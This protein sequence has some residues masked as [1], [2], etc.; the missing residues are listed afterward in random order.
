MIHRFLPFN[1]YLSLLFFGI[2]ML[3]ASG[4]AAGGNGPGIVITP[5]LQY[6]YAQ[7]LFQEQDHIAAQVEFKRFIHFFPDDPRADESE[8]KIGI[9][10]YRSGQFNGAARIFNTI[11]NKEKI[12][13]DY[14]R[15]SYF[16][17]SKAF[18]AMDNPGYAGVV[19]QNF[20][21]LT[22]DL[23][24]KDRIY[25]ELA[26]LHI[27]ETRKLG[28]NKLDQAETYLTL[29]S[30]ERKK[31]YKTSARL[32]AITKVRSAPQKNPTLGGIL[33]LIPGGGFLYCERYKDAFVTF[34]LNAGLIY[35]AYEAFNS[36]NPG[37]GGVISFVESGFYAGNIYGSISAAHKYN[38]LQQIKILYQQF[39]ITAGIDPGGRSYL[40]TFNHPF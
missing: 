13:N 6:E 1:S 40:I 8:F 34:C 37:L 39:N 19:L 4:L 36:D 27:R 38:K 30:P 9:A 28:K 31:E 5:D 2:F 12:E 33:A 3:M 22:D 32:E 20:L 35:G 25:L 18:L 23:A 16:M 26:R 15:E 7:E 17:Q 11:I 29:I 14:T 10:L 21:K 24:T